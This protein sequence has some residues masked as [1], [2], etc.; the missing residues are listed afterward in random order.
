MDYLEELYKP[1]DNLLSK[2]ASKG[3][4]VLFNN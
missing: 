4:E 3:S 2:G 1:V